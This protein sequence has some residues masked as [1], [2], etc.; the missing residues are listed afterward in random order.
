MASKVVKFLCIH[1]WCIEKRVHLFCVILY[2]IKI[3]ENIIKGELFLEF[4][5]NNKHTNLAK[6]VKWK[7]IK[8]KIVH[9]IIEFKLVSLLC[10]IIEFELE[11]H[12]FWHVTFVGL[13]LK[14]LAKWKSIVDK[15]V[16]TSQIKHVKSKLES[17]S[18]VIVSN[19]ESKYGMTAVIEHA[20]V[21][22]NQQHNYTVIPVHCI[23]DLT[24]YYDPYDRQ[25]FVIDGFSYDEIS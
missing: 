22:M 24:N 10:T 21:H 11:Q 2:Q 12:H 7:W 25:L 14:Q 15:T 3:H 19:K 18:C 17:N 8:C 23:S 5:V 6:Q 1:H 16:E 9:S 4:C 20:T 13:H